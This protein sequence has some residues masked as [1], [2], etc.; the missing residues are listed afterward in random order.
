MFT[1][2]TPGTSCDVRRRRLR[3]PPHSH[4]VHVWRCCREARRTLGKRFPR[5]GPTTPFRPPSACLRDGRHGNSNWK[6]HT[7]VQVATTYLYVCCSIMECQSSSILPA[8]YRL[9]QHQD[10]SPRQDRKVYLVPGFRLGTVTTGAVVASIAVCQAWSPAAFASRR[11]TSPSFACVATIASP[12]ASLVLVSEPSHI[13]A[14]VVNSWPKSTAEIAVHTV[15]TPCPHR[16]ALGV[17]RGRQE[18]LSD[19]QELSRCSRARMDRLR[20]LAQGRSREVVM[21]ALCRPC[22]ERNMLSRKSGQDAD[23]T[24]CT[25][26]H[27][28]AAAR[29]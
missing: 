27:Q 10:H 26:W 8:G 7:C 6:L 2:G 5:C 15:S 11:H 21:D 18:F 4:S 24:S 29:R 17:L 13:L 23:V 20:I 22:F 3:Q 1:A 28:S 16:G 14:V 9:L 12:K 25:P 19:T